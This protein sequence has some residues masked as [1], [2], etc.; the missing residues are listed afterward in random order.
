M[1]NNLSSR[2]SLGPLSP[3]NVVST[4][5]VLY[6]SHF[7][8]YLTLAANAYLWMLVPIYGWA[9]YF[10]ISG[11][12]SRLAF[13]EL[14]GQPETVKDARHQL[15]S[16]LWSFLGVAFQ[17]GIYL[18]LVYLGLLVGL[19]IVGLI[20]GF[21]LV[22]LLSLLFNNQVVTGVVTVLLTIIF[23]IIFLVGFI[24]YFSRWMI[25]ELPLAVEADIQGGASVKRSWDL[26]KKS[27][28]RIQVI[29]FIAFLVTLPLVAFT[30]YVPQ[31]FLLMIE[32]G[33]Q[34][35]WLI[36]FI[37]LFISFLGGMMILPFWQVI[38]AVLYYDLR[39]RREGFDLLS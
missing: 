26:T 6:R 13:Q 1:S 36:Y 12:I 17:V 3:G 16:K 33:S 19:V 32:E 30:N 38:K 22:F 35:Y 4:A 21:T 25:A 27:V 2:E 8:T 5:L 20:V 9:K 24:W 7:K 37:S 23:V 39:S 28:R 18:T 31:I 10:T 11:I 29:V 14:I 34:L 15:K